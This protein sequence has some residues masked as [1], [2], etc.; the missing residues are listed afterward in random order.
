[1][2]NSRHPG[3]SCT[4]GESRVAAKPRRQSQR[5]RTCRRTVQSH[6]AEP[7]AAGKQQEGPTWDKHQRRSGSFCR[8]GEGN[9][10]IE[11]QGPDSCKWIVGSQGRWIC[12]YLLAYLGIIFQ[13]QFP[14][15]SEPTCLTWEENNTKQNGNLKASW[16]WN[17][18]AG[19]S[20]EGLHRCFWVFVF[21]WKEKER[22]LWHIAGERQQMW[23]LR[24]E[25]GWFRVALEQVVCAEWWGRDCTHVRLWGCSHIHW[26]P[27]PQRPSSSQSESRS[28]A[29]LSLL[30]ASQHSRQYNSE[31]YNSEHP[32]RSLL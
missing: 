11:K 3:G 28:R 25:S 17:W 10:Q 20:W 4:T 32:G 1:M 18:W 21:R 30:S 6:A 29:L 9:H 2:P 5:L 19:Y 27:R 13:P 12:F 24:K 26:E 16:L 22:E 8:K 14:S 7:P 15:L 23:A 31:P